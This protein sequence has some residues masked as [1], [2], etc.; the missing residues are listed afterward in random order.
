VRQA[1]RVAKQNNSQTPEHSSPL[2]QPK[3]N[4]GECQ[5]IKVSVRVSKQ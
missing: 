1:K 4:G 2:A 3:Y 5:R